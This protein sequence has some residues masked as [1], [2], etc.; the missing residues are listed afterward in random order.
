MFQKKTEITRPFQGE[1]EW[2]EL[3]VGDKIRC[4]VYDT[5][6]SGSYRW[7]ENAEVVWS[8]YD[9]AFYIEGWTKSD[10]GEPGS[11]NKVGYPVSKILRAKESNVFLQKVP[12][13]YGDTESV[14]WSILSDLKSFANEPPQPEF[15]ADEFPISPEYAVSKATVEMVIT[16][17]SE[18]GDM[19]VISKEDIE[20]YMESER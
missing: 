4:R 3:W 15:G 11:M 7:I 14:V 8:D 20:A 12:R 5:D 16:L 13:K 1:D 17:V 6:R 19:G 9:K 2:V 10:Y 18:I